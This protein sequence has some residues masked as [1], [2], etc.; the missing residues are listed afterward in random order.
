MVDAGT[1]AGEARWC[2]STEQMS[3]LVMTEDYPHCYLQGTG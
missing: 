1:A 3:N 2:A